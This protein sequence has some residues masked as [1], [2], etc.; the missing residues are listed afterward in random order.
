MAVT[1]VPA[2]KIPESVQRF[3]DGVKVVN[4]EPYMVEGDEGQLWTW[5]EEN[6][7]WYYNTETGEIRMRKD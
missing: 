1:I 2:I 5:V 7:H 4:D 3:E 6:N